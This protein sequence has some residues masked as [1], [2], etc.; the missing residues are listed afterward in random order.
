MIGR[1][2]ELAQ[3]R[4]FLSDAV[5]RLGAL[6]VSGP[7]GIGKSTLW[8][9]ALDEAGAR[10]YRV[11]STRPSEA[12]A[13]LPFA[14]LNDLFGT[15]LD[16]T[17][18]A[19]P[20]PQR[21]ALDMALLRVATPPEAPPEPLA[22][23]LATLQLVRAASRN[24][25]LV[26]A[27]D[28]V[29]WLDGASASVL[30]FVVRRLA[31]EPIALVATERVSDERVTFRLVREVPIERRRAI[32]VSPMS[33][34]ETGRLLASAIGLDLPP[35]SVSRIH[36]LAGGNPFYAVEIGRA[37]RRRGGTRVDGD[38]AVPSSLAG[39]ISDRL[40]HL[41]AAGSVVVRY[42][43][44][45]S[46][47]SVRALESALGP[48]TVAAGVADAVGADIL[49]LNA[50][51]VRFTHPL[52][53]ADAYGRMDEVTRRDVHR[54]LGE[55]VTE[56]EERATHLDASTSG[57]DGTIAGVLDEAAARAN[58]RGAPEAAAEHAERAVRR[59][60]GGDLLTRR[61]I[62]AAGYR[63]RS[64]D[65]ARA[66]A[67]LE[68]ALVDATPGALRAETLVRL[69]QVR[70]LGD[71]WREA[72]RL[73]EEA[74]VEADPGVPHRIEALVLRAGISFVTTRHRERGLALITEAFRLADD[75][76]DP[77]LLARVIGPYATWQ[78]EVG[79][80]ADLDAI[81]RRAADLGTAGDHL[82][83]ADHFDADFAQIKAMSGDHQ[84]ARTLWERLLV[85]AEERGDYSSIPQFLHLQTRADFYAG[86]ADDALA[87]LEEAEPLARSTGH[88]TALMSVL[89]ERAIV[90][91]RTGR[92]EAAWEAVSAAVA[93]RAGMGMTSLADHPRLREELAVLELSRGNYEAALEALGADVVIEADR[94][95]LDST[96]PTR[97]EALVRLGRLDEAGEV[98]ERFS[99]LAVGRPFRHASADVDAGASRV[100][101]LLAAARGDLEEAT[102]LIDEAFE[103]Y[104]TSNDSWSRARALLAAADIHRRS[105]RRSQA[106]AAASEALGLFEHFGAALWAERAR[107][108]LGRIGAA[109]ADAARLTPTQAQVV[110]LAIQGLT[111][112]QIGDRLFMSFHTV[113]AHLSAAYRALGIGSRRE[114]SSVRRDPA[115]RLRDPL[116]VEDADT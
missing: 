57:H 95:A 46:Q 11:V 92:P 56:V 74:L 98:L 20:A 115:L 75:S 16:E 68:T 102:R 101:A 38:V 90:C 86:R 84:G 3:I 14:A 10:G 42:A 4:E 51:A 114:L 71:D 109:H 23:S 48:D 88:G 33:A 79:R 64:G 106:R 5:Q 49:E 89:H 81:E 39:L 27:I 25:P 104:S 108:V 72:E 99:G 50:D 100:G 8:R 7:A 93:Q 29:Q 52:L 97:A 15:L 62:A 41:S 73:L 85:R 21:I 47:A 107:E 70:L 59:T 94:E 111:N 32:G 78:W 44:A 55:I 80:H 69:G 26:V 24:R 45:L 40:G 103:T 22:V 37:M 19:L 2:A 1:D 54:R 28:D 30:E 34:R 31:A 110:E 53:A 6:H 43:S 65:M 116:T 63:M 113:E 17:E 91:A 77:T 105:R 36:A 35:S 9:V 66:R 58:E 82:R 87:R 13:Q 83:V 18:P 67:L 96:L 112:R 76:G 12:E 61:R 60:P